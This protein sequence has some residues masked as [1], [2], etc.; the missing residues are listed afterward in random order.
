MIPPMP[1]GVPSASQMRQSSPVSPRLRPRTPTVR[2]TP[3]RV[4]MRLARAG[5]AHREAAAGQQRDVVG[6]GGLPE[7]EHDVVRGVDHV[8]DRAACRPGGGAG[9]SVGATGPPSTLRS[10][11]T[12][13]RGHRSSDSTA[14][15]AADSTGQPLARGNG[16]SGAVNSRPRR[17]ARSRATPTML[18]ASGRLPSTARSKT[19]SCTSPSASIS[20]VPGSP[21]ASS[22]RIS[23]P[24]ASSE[25][26]SSVPEQSMPLETTPFILRWPISK[27]PG[28]MAPTGA[29]G[30]RSPTSKLWAPQTISTGSPVPASTRTRRILSAPLMAEISRTRLTTT[31]ASPSPTYSM[32]STTRPRS[33]SAA[34]STPTSPGNWAK[35]RSQL[36]G[37][38]ERG[39]SCGWAGSELRE[40]ADVVLQERT[41]VRN[42]VAH[43]G[44]AVDAEPEGETGP[45]S[46]CRSRPRR[47]PR[48]RPCRSRRAR[49]SPCASRSG[50]PHPGT[51]CR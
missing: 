10:T 40:E 22:P 28:R 46:R 31:S 11:L 51:G 23:R 44:Q 42:G 35:S 41:H 4:S 34:R 38:R 21:G 14:A 3:S 17:A 39:S 45:D 26:P 32:P 18:Q 47:T 24:A 48:G 33:S 9:R 12:V 36:S 5:P 6:V 50:T 49:S 29:S 30:T 37:A 15:L 20:G 16:G 2:S 27:P 43:L 19:T 8:V 25:R 13:R 7:L 1:T